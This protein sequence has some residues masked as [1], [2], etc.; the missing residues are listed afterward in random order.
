MSSKNFYRIWLPVSLILHAALLAVLYTTK[1]PEA[2][3]APSLDE[4]DFVAVVVDPAPPEID[5][6]ALPVQPT[7]AAAGTTLPRGVAHPNPTESEEITEKD[8]VL[9]PG[10][11]ATM[12]PS[13]LTAPNGAFKVPVGQP[14]GLG[15]TDT[16]EVGKPSGESRGASRQGT[17]TATYPK[18]ALEDGIEG[19]VIVR[20]PVDADGRAG[21]PEIVSHTPASLN[22]AALSTIRRMHFRAALKN[23]EPAA[24]TVTLRFIFA[25]G[26]V[27]IE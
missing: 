16:G 9:G 19:T 13:M 17:A 24:D 14:R 21:T 5:V 26:T 11:G 23:G 18:L 25:N 8:D 1:L 4:T 27:N 2:A 10:S 6:P 22:N 7:L 20:V 15:N 12:A 3:A